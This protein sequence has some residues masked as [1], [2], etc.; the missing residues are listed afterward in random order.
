MIAETM[1]EKRVALRE[2]TN[3][4]IQLFYKTGKK[5]SCT[6]TKIGKLLSILAFKY[7]KSGELLFDEIIYKYPLCCGT[8]IKDL[9]FIVRRSVYRRDFREADS[10]KIS[11]IERC[12]L[13][14]SAYIPFDYLCVKSLEISLIRD[15]ED[16]FFRF[17]AYPTDEL[18]RLLTPIADKL[19][20]GTTNVL[21]LSRLVGLKKN[22]FINASGNKI[23]EYLYQE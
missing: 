11:W 3:Y 14:N 21:E 13:N 12:E 16:V 15:I 17:G 20:A 22:D 7:A 4:L 23:V 1:I 19:V 5:Y 10:D 8:L 6:Q 18:G 9:Q 2:A